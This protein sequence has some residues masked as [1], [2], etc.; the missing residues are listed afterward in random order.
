MDEYQKKR[1]F[2]KTAEP[3][4]RRT[5]GRQGKALS[6]VVQKHDATRLHYDFRLELDGVLKS[7]AVTK[8]PS[9]NPADKRL[10]VR[11][12]DHPLDYG[13]FE[14][15]IP[16]GEYGGGTVM[17]W[18]E[19]TWEPIGDP[20]EGLEQGELK[21][22]L[23]GK[24]MKGS[25]VL[26]HMK[27]RDSGGREN[28]LLIKHRDEYAR[29]SDGLTDRF[30]TSVDTG[31]DLEGIARGLKSR[32]KSSQ[33]AK[34]A[35]KAKSRRKLKS[36]SLT[37]DMGIA[38]AEQLGVKLTSP[39]RIVYPDEGIT[40]A[41]LVAYYAAVAERMLAYVGE[42]PLS[43]VRAPQG[44]KGQTFF[45]KH[46]NGGFSDQVK[47]IPIEEKLEDGTKDHMYVTDAAGL[48][49]C[50]QM[51][52]LEFHIW[53]ARTKNV[54]KAERIIFDIDPD[55]GLDFAEVR[56]AAVHIRD[57][58]GSWGLESFPMVTG[59]KGIHVIAPVKAIA[60]WP[61]VKDFCHAF[62]DRLE[63]TQ[64]DRFTSNI[65]KVKRQGRMFVD[66]LRN[67]RGSTAIGPFS[68]RARAGAPVSVPIG[69]DEIETLDRANGFSLETAVARALEKDPWPNYFKLTQSITK[70]M[71]EA[72]AGPVK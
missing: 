26:V 33:S 8:G 54:E 53:G 5:A 32:R 50:V 15:T 14:G 9:A 12:E 62:A 65:R 23:H 61:L 22:V 18:D 10:A 67:E 1:D 34:P 7:W 63:A 25:W 29:E 49:A 16:K 68:T 58:L 30:T 46:D 27:G 56:S 52:T 3:S 72:V 71:V 36:M 19:G 39:D 66:Y 11:V 59:G 60:E 42:R 35:T 6:F 13:D 55:E 28:W 4:G 31:R 48:V 37:D 45:Q 69:W 38:A 64:P 51:N 44:L 70:G 21:F 40:K 41:R 43:L 2:S 17:L 57:A 24:R 47:K 20:H